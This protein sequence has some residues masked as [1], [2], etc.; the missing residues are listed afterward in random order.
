MQKDLYISETW[1]GILW[2]S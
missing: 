2:K 1:G